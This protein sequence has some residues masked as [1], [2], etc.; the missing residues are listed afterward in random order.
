VVANLVVSYFRGEVAPAN[1]FGGATLEWSVSSPPPDFNFPVIPRVTSPYPM[2]DAADREQDREVLA[3]GERTLT[4]GHETQA[5]TVHQAEW[6][7]ILAMPSSSPWPIVVAA[8]TAAVFTS[9]LIGQWVLAA[10]CAGVGLL[11]LTAWH[12]KEPLEA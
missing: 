2:W 6:D 5:T 4:I 8:M 3:R 7:E 10:A 1:P 9:L 12:A 11:V